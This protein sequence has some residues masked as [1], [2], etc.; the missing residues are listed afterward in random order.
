MS[1]QFFED[2][3][4]KDFVADLK[5]ALEDESMLLLGVASMHV[6]TVRL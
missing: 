2:N 5:G 6:K 3:L 1:T 4:G